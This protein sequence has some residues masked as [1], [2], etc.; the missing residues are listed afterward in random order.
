MF[1]HFNGNQLQKWT[2]LGLFS[3]TA[4][5]LR[6]RLRGG[7]ALSRRWEVSLSWSVYIEPALLVDSLLELIFTCNLLSDNFVVRRFLVG[8]MVGAFLL[9][10]LLVYEVNYQ[11]NV[12]ST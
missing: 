5:H 11:E 9:A 4:A 12:F 3:C 10:F 1:T 8:C 7:S 2:L 6:L